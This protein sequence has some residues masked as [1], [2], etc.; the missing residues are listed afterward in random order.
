[1]KILFYFLIL[2]LCNSCNKID[3]LSVVGN[4]AKL[5]SAIDLFIKY[6]S[7]NDNKK[8]ITLFAKNINAET[9]I[10]ILNDSPTVYSDE[11]AKKIS[12]QEKTK[13]GYIRYKGYDIFVSSELQKY[14]DLNYKSVENIFFKGKINEETIPIIS[15]YPVMWIVL[16]PNKKSLKYSIPSEG[17]TWKNLN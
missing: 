16:V 8:A 17:I 14:F 4:N 13:F 1:M 11:I 6:M 10:T 5:N 7:E 15:D 3:D 9:N 2:I 12:N